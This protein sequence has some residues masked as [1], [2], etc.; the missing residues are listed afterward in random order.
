[1]G[2]VSASK[3]Q[4][5]SQVF[6]TSL[7]PTL[8]PALILAFLSYVYTTIDNKRKDEL[9][10]VRGQIVDLY[11]PLYTLTSALETVWKNLGTRPETSLDDVKTPP[12]RE[13]LESAIAPMSNQIETTLLSSKQIVRCTLVRAELQ[14]FV[15]FAESVKMAVSNWK[16]DGEPANTAKPA[17]SPQIPAK[18]TPA[19]LPYPK[20]LLSLLEGELTAL[21]RRE[22]TLDNGFLGL[23]PGRNESECPKAPVK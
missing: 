14:K 20:D 6:F 9:E 12:G 11:G 19:L 5:F 4:S 15:A 16:S 23:F 8:F 10:F 1:M 21:H 2:H 13:L 18:N 22:N 17:D 3:P 7:A